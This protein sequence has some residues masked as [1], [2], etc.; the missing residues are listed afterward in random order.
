MPVVEGK[1]VEPFTVRLDRCDLRLAAGAALPGHELRAGANRH[2]LAYRDVASASN[3]L[4][5]IAAIVPPGA[6]TVHT[7]FCL[8]GAMPLDD[9]A[10]LCCLLN[11]FVANW[12]VR[13]WV[14]THLGTSTVERLPVPRPPAS[15]AAGGRLRALGLRLLTSAG[16]DA[17]AH[18]E[19]QGLAAALYGLDPGEFAL[20][21]DTL[22]LVDA[23]VKAAAADCH[24]H[25]APGTRRV[26]TLPGARGT[27]DDSSDR[28]LQ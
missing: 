13:L 8:R 24:R 22:P 12:L 7:L 1:H 21:L 25:L 2:R 6:I 15:S 27:P 28:G 5:L 9:Q 23:G 10:A 26:Y 14:T 4:T 17:G 3:R 18:A 16:Q 19:A 11:S 20:V